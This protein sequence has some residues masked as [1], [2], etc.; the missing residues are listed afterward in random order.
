MNARRHPA[1]GGATLRV[2]EDQRLGGAQR[3]AD[4]LRAGRV[5]DAQ[6]HREIA[7]LCRSL[8]AIDAVLHEVRA[9]HCPETVGGACGKRGGE[10]QHDERDQ[11]NR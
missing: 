7:C 3:A 11:S 8:E 4:L 2:P 9:L 5:V 6:E 10:R 1:H